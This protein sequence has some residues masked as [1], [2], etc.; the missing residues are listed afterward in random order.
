MELRSVAK[1]LGNNCVLTL[2]FNLLTMVTIHVQQVGNTHHLRNSELVR[3]VL[4][5]YISVS[6]IYNLKE[7]DMNY[8]VFIKGVANSIGNIR[9]K[10]QEWVILN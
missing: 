2:V 10:T 1:V 8:I 7:K 6:Y 9:L 5:A 4:Q 3:I